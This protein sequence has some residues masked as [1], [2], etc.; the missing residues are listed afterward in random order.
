MTWGISAYMNRRNLE[1]IHIL[2]V[3]DEKSIRDMLQSTIN[4][5]GYDCSIAGDA[6]DAL[7]ILDE[8][9]V[10]VVITDIEMPG[11][12]GIEL[13][14]IIKEKYDSDV[15]V[16]TGFAKDLKYEEVIE[17][18]ANDFMLKPFNIEEMLIRVKHV[19]N[20][21]AILSGLNHTEKELKNSLFEIDK[22]SRTNS[23]CTFICI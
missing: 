20:E 3:D 21:R 12:S 5:A 14:G 13:T 1:H 4:S 9:N 2:V 7:K 17:K 23:Q 10:D 18:G 19:L 11:L 15:I 8:K 16:M 6:S 22:N